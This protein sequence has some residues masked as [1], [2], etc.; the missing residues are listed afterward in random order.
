MT[1]SREP[2]SVEDLDPTLAVGSLAL[3]VAALAIG[4]ILGLL[5]LPDWLPGLDQSLRGETPHAP[6]YI[7]RASGLVAFALLWTSTCSGLLI[8]TRIARDLKL[9]PAV[10]DIHQHLAL[11]AL[12][13]AFLHAGVLGLDKYIG[14]GGFELA[15]PFST[16][17]FKPIAMGIGQVAFY[18]AFVGTITAYFRR[19]LGK[20]AWHVIH[21]AGSI[22]F[23]FALLHGIYAGSSAGTKGLVAAYAIAAASTLLLTCYRW[24]KGRAAQQ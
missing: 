3:L 23:V 11:T 22:S 17:R 21:V 6:W 5:V 13:F 12:A 15:F 4:G 9:S 1:S 10:L 7:C 16:R 18:L 24:F 8:S 19:D 20:T 2:Q 14:F